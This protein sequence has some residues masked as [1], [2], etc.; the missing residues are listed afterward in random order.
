MSTQI[1]FPDLTG[2]EPTRDTLHTY[3]QVI[4]LIPRAHLE[5]HPKWFHISYKVQPDGLAT[6]QMPLPDGGVFWLKLD[7]VNHKVILI[8]RETSVAEFNMLEGISASA[9]GGQV[10]RALSDLGLKADYHLKKFESDEPQSYNAIFAGKYL[11]VLVNVDR[12]FKKHRDALSGERTPVQLWPHNFD[13]AFEWYGSRLVKYTQNDKEIESPAQLSL[14]FSPGDS[15][16]PRPY[17]YSNPWPFEK[18]FLVNKPLPAGASWFTESWQGSILPYS[19]LVGD[20]NGEERLLEYA[21]S[22]YQI[23]APTLMG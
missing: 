10:I 20:S 5:F 15:S 7:L 21:R 3:C 22:V 19:E 9:F 18:E 23:C 2:W 16:H 6:K 12:I 11:T 1:I 13:M 8:A 4:S 14:G 17:F